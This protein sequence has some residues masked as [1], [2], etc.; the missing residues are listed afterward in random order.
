MAPHLPTECEYCGEFTHTQPRCH[1][2]VSP[3]ED[4]SAPGMGV[5]RSELRCNICYAP[6]ESGLSSLQKG[7]AT[8]LYRKWQ[9]GD[10]DM[11]EELLAYYQKTHVEW[12]QGETA[13]MVARVRA[14]AQYRVAAGFPPVDYPTGPGGAVYL[15]YTP[16]EEGEVTMEMF[17][18]LVDATVYIHVGSDKARGN[19][20]NSEMSIESSLSALS[21]QH[22][23]GM[24]HLSHLK[25]LG[26]VTGLGG[27][28]QAHIPV[29]LGSRRLG[30]VTL[31]DRVGADHWIS[32]GAYFE[33]L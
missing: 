13:G 8:N 28:P 17:N 27:Q 33:I 22:S 2:F 14:D 6:L 1:Y 23:S 20:T 11:A 15:P 3:S 24:V 5:S 31:D 25:A 32:I 4:P 30:N 9:E 10:A 7:H 29:L 12:C 21:L 19:E 18:K 26:S 16:G